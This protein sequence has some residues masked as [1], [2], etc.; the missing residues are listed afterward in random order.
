[1][2]KINTL[3]FLFLSQKT[4]SHHHNK[5]IACSTSNQFSMIASNKQR[6]STIAE[7]FFRNTWKQI[8]ILR[9]IGVRR[10]ARSYARSG[11]LTK[12]VSAMP[13]HANHVSQL[14]V[15]VVCIGARIPNFSWTGSKTIDLVRLGSSRCNKPNIDLSIFHFPLLR[16][17]LASRFTTYQSWA[18]VAYL[19]LLIHASIDEARAINKNQEQYISPVLFYLC[20]ERFLT[21]PIYSRKKWYNTFLQY[22]SI[23]VKKC[24]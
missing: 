16:V 3:H 11:L 15:V 24:S 6:I 7:Y 20:E 22:C 13:T 17:G 1:M 12:Y 9:R 23:C 18:V 10:E 19:K 4:R 8:P 5:N 21:F 2:N 14:F